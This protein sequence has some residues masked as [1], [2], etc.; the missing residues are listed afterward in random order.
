MG[1]AGRHGILCMCL[2]LCVR[3]WLLWSMGMVGCLMWQLARVL[4]SWSLRRPLLKVWAQG[5]VSYMMLRGSGMCGILGLG[6]GRFRGGGGVW[7]V[8]Y[9]HLTLPTK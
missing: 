9:T 8:S 6:L 2:M 4:L 1:M 3:M 7:S 5:L